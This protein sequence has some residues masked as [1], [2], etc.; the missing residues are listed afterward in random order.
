MVMVF[1]R[2][3]WYLRGNKNLFAYEVP[4]FRILE[5]ELQFSDSPEIRI[6]KIFYNR[7]LWIQKQDRNSAYNG[8]PRNWNQKLE[9]PT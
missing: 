5:S 1:F 7:N 3:P 6:Q 9:F 4:E 8:G 2:E